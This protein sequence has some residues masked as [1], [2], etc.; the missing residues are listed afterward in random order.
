MWLWPKQKHKIQMTM[1]NF[2]LFSLEL[3]S[4][5]LQMSCHSSAWE[6]SIFPKRRGGERKFS[7][8]SVSGIGQS[9]APARKPCCSPR[10]GPPAWTSSPPWNQFNE[11]PFR[12]KSFRTQ[13]LSL[14]NS[15]ANFHMASVDNNLGF[16]G[17]KSHKKSSLQTFIKN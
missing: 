13:F 5:F 14:N 6:W 10:S 11:S 3:S 17:T 15:K 7:R 9:E 4:I 12:P 2:S 1:T 16:K 8:S